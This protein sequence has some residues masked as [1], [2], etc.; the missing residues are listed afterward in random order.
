MEESEFPKLNE[1]VC[2]TWEQ[3]A[4]FWNQ[5]MGEGNE[6]HRI[7]I[8]PAQER[9]LALQPGETVLDIGCGNGQFARR[10]L[11]L[12][13][14]VLAL[15]SSRR[16]IDNARANTQEHQERI[17]YRWLDATDPSALLNLGANRFDAAVC[18]M[19]MMDMACIDP[20]VASL[21]QLLRPAGRF[22]FSVLHPCFNSAGV[23]LMTQ[24]ANTPTGLITRYSVLIPSTS[25]R[26]P[27]RA[28]R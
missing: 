13:T 17:E 8:G 5:R 23:T 24:E 20:L 27:Q 21:S 11:Q 19:A 4:D 9:L 22:V 7:L 14:R 26:R 6:F 1:E 18:T 12:G 25:V 28:W 15:D 2:A 10:M 16:M 3:N